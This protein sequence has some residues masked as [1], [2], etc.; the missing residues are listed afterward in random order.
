MGISPYGGSAGQPG[1]G[2]ST[3]DFDIWLKGAQ[4]VE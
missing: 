4:E 3:R 2:S 1:L